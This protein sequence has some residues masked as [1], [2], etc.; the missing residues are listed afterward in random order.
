MCKFIYTANIAEGLQL[1]IE[2]EFVCAG[3]AGVQC[4]H[5]RFIHTKNIRSRSLNRSST[6]LYDN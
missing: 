2:C 3:K 1:I 4:F 5:W 6:F